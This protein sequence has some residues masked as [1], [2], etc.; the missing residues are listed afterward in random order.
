MERIKQLH[1]PLIVGMG[2]FTF[3]HP[4]MNLT[5]MMDSIG[6]PIGPLSVMVLISG[7][8]LALVLMT[9]VRQPVLTLTFTGIVSGIFA[10]GS[11]ALLAPLLTGAPFAPLANPWLLP[12]ALSSILITNTLWGLAVGLVAWAIQH[13]RQ[14]DNRPTNGRVP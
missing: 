10:I 3:V 4:L 1:W 14:A 12:F 7:A 11:G 13:G 2:A 8:W 9:R 6:R 5:G